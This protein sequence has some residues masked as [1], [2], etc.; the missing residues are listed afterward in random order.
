MAF[1]TEQL[2]FSDPEFPRQRREDRQLVVP[3]YRR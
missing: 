2:S 1:L 3:A